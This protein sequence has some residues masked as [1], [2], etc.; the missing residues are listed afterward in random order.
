MKQLILEI[1]NSQYRDWIM[2]FIPFILAIISVIVKWIN[3][4]TNKPKK[5]K[6][7]PWVGK[8]DVIDKNSNGDRQL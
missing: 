6:D 7:L 4:N 1:L 8:I 2:F 5:K 3:R